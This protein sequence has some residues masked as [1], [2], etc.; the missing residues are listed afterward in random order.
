MALNLQPCFPTQ[1][2]HDLK[3]SISSHIVFLSWLSPNLSHLSQLKLH[4]SPT[5]SPYQHK[6]SEPTMNNKDIIITWEI[7]RIQNYLPGTKDKGQP[8]FLLNNYSLIN[9]ELLR[10]LLCLQ[11]SILYLGS[12]H[13][14]FY[15]YQTEYTK[16][17]AFYP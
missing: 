8:N 3:P 11:V 17:K 9:W 4:R 2:S 14:L 10:F 12:T 15:M 7:P 13:T 5:E 6:P 16:R 1:R